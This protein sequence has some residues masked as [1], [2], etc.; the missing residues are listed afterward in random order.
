MRK[1]YG[2]Y[3]TDT[4]PFCGKRGVINNK[5]GIPVCQ[6]HKARELQDMK[7]ACGEWLDICSGKWGPYFRCM[8]CGNITFRKGLDMNPQAKTAREITITSDEVDIIY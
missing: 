2:E 1:V 5:Q 7:C 8:K 6:E 3:R 4:C